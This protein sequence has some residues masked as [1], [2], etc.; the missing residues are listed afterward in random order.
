MQN[1]FLNNDPLLRG[2]QFQTPS[3]DEMDAYI[4][5]L[6]E[7]QERIQQQKMQILS[8]PSQ[9]Q[10]KCPVWDEI[11]NVISGLTDT[12]FQ[13]I[14]ET[15]DF[16]ESNQIVMNILNRE[17]MKMMRPVVENTKDGKE[18]LQ[19]HLSLIKKLKKAI[20]DE[21]AKNIELFNEYTEKYSDMTYAEFLEMK[22]KGG[23]K[24]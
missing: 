8:G 1:I 9:S 23:K 2:G 22:K 3:T 5:K 14:S 7:A 13:K 17:Y 24:K 16:A 6:Q 12:E 21:S 4:Q 15:R 19:N 11:E 10:S 20:T 18:A